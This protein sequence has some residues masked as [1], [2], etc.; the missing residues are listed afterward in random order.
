[1]ET[2]SHPLPKRFVIYLPAV[3]WEWEDL[4][5]GVELLLCRRFGGLTTYPATGLFQRET[6]AIQRESVQVL[7][8]YGELE[9][10]PEDR[11]ILHGLAGILAAVME[12]EAI[13]CS[14][15][16]RMHFVEPGVAGVPT[17]DL[18]CG[19]RE[20]LSVRLLKVKAAAATSNEPS[21]PW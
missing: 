14:V 19:D 8:C 5:A 17:H 21:A 20:K 13:A 15:D 16:G 18:T 11:L 2:P 10:W 6:G 12:Q 7:E 4:L 3:K 1:M 9:S